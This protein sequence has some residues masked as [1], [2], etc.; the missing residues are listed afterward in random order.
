[1]ADKEMTADQKADAAMMEIWRAWFT[2]YKRHFRDTNIAISAADQMA[3]YEIAQPL[4]R[5]LANGGR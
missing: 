5:K 3:F 1:M 2:F 4:M